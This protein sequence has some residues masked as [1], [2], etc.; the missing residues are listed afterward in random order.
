MSIVLVGGLDRLH[1]EYKRKAKQFGHQ[2]KVYTQ[3]PTRFAK[4]IGTPD[5]IVVFTATSSHQMVKTALE[6]A[7]KNNIP[8][9]RCHNSS[10]N[11][12]Q[13]SIAQLEALYKQQAT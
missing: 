7:R 6:H 12:F 10:T 13:Q 4:M 5:G 1:A 9:I 3:M 11:S 2:V 8:V